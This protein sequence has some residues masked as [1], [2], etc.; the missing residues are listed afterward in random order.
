M[1]GAD[2]TQFTRLDKLMQAAA[3]RTARQAAKPLEGDTGHIFMLGKITREQLVDTIRLQLAG[4]GFVLGSFQRHRLQAIFQLY[5]GTESHGLE[6]DGLRTY[7]VRGLYGRALQRDLQIYPNPSICTRFPSRK[8]SAV[9]SL[10]EMSTAATS[11]GVTV[12]RPWIRLARSSVSIVP[13]DT[14]RA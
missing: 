6:T 10:K 5:L 7:L 4:M 12:H 8:Y 13:D 14:I 11:A 9:T 2:I 3:G 1:A